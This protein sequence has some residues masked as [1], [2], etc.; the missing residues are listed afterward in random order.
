[1]WK[2]HRPPNDD[3]ILNLSQHFASISNETPGSFPLF[4]NQNVWLASDYSG[5][6]GAS[7][8]F[9]ASLLLIDFDLRDLWDDARRQA[10]E[11]HLKDNRRLS[12]KALG[13]RRRA[14]SLSDFLDAANDLS[15]I[16]ISFGVHKKLKPL[17]TV[18]GDLDWAKETLGLRAR[19]KPKT[20]EHLMRLTTFVTFV[21]GGLVQD[22]QDIMWVTDDDDFTGKH[23]RMVDVTNVLRFLRSINQPS[24]H[25][26]A[27]FQ[28]V[29]ATPNEKHQMMFEDLCSIPDLAAGALSELWTKVS[30]D[31]DLNVSAEP[32]ELDVSEVSEKSRR[33]YEWH[34]LRNTR[35]KRLL[36][37]LTPDPDP[38]ISFRVLTPGPPPVPTS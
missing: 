38:S 20:F 21:C 31:V 3:F 14:S 1:M 9:V 8:F 12:F 29:S 5:G 36:C 37:L 15:G 6:R 35:L 4:L 27:L 22:H 25:G 2:Q 10:R 23:D 7:D 24:H 16:L 28:A 17:F 32:I 11:E 30:R 18:P 33:I 26:E 13:D 34:M 19:W